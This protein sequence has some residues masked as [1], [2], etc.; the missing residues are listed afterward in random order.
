MRTIRFDMIFKI[1]E[2]DEKEFLQK[3]KDFL[4]KEKGSLELYS[5]KELKSVEEVLGL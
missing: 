4:K 1:E 5:D 3:I 2:Y